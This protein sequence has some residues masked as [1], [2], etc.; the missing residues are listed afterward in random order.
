MTLLSPALCKA[1]TSRLRAELVGR[2]DQSSSEIYRSSLSRKA[3]AIY[4]PTNARSKT[5]DGICFWAKWK[6]SKF[7]RVRVRRWIKR[8]E[9][10]ARARV[11]WTR[12]KHCHPG[13]RARQTW[14]PNCGCQ[15]KDSFYCRKPQPF[16]PNKVGGSRQ[17]V[18]ARNTRM[19]TKNSMT[20]GSKPFSRFRKALRSEYRSQKRKPGCEG[21]HLGFS[22]KSEA[23]KAKVQKYF[24]C[25]TVWHHGCCPHTAGRVCLCLW[26]ARAG[27]VAFLNSKCAGLIEGRTHASKQKGWVV[28]VWAASSD[29]QWF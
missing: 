29:R 25:K 17:H 7:C 3:R 19:K 22:Q 21:A 4:I 8:K 14:R 9:C 27:D 10:R 20:K 18:W 16:C 28:Q 13:F 5:N 24:S 2:K 6:A 12:Q 11:L 15:T 26:N 23:Q 1:G